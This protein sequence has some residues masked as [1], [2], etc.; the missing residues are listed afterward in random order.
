[1]TRMVR[2]RETSKLSQQ[3]YRNRK[4]EKERDTQQCIDELNRT[5]AQWRDYRAA[6]VS[7]AL[8]TSTHR[9]THRYQMMKTY[10]DLYSRG[11]GIEGTALSNTQRRFLQVNC[12]DT[13]ELND[14]VF[15]AGPEGLHGQW[16]RYSML[17]PQ[18]TCAL[19]SV[20]SPTT[21][22]NVVVLYF[23]MV[24]PLRHRSIMA[25]YPHMA[26]NSIFMKKTLGKTLS[27]DVVKTFHFD[28]MNKIVQM[29]AEFDMLQPW[30]DLL[31][32]MEM[33]VE[34][35]A[36]CKLKTCLIDMNDISIEQAI[37][38]ESKQTRIAMAKACRRGRPRID[39]DYTDI[40]VQQPPTNPSLSPEES[41]SVLNI[42]S[43]SLHDFISS[44]EQY[45]SEYPTV[46]VVLP[47]LEYDASRVI[48]NNTACGAASNHNKG[49]I[50]F[51]LG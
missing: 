18:I 11:A 4:K 7:G 36:G 9:A 37:D 42:S 41:K 35:I 16:V 50:S 27:C 19:Q 5:L 26:S 32:D 43:L 25:L 33:A 46:S 12:S 1:M 6:I 48:P 44:V 28:D 39:Q 40:D 2:R 3:R 29:S 13:T 15:A 21:L 45:P 17:H 49:D 20:K 47:S 34:V 38:L 23:E 51:I 30:V 8:L 24:L 14:S 31:Q 10:M 22:A